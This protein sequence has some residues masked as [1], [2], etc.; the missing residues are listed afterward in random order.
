MSLFE[1][2]KQKTALKIAKYGKLYGAAL[3]LM[4]IAEPVVA[5]AIDR[6]CA[7]DRTAV[8][9]ST[10]FLPGWTADRLRKANCFHS[11][12]E[13]YVKGHV[14]VVQKKLVALL[15]VF[16]GAHLIILYA[17]SDLFDLFLLFFF[18]VEQIAP[19]CAKQK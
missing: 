3:E 19:P 7:K 15:K 4:T 12:R 10:F 6:L 2:T 18:H 14:V 5:Q 8:G 17:D 16:V 9:E 1:A 11:A 13:L